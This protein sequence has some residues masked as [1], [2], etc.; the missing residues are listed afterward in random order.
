MNLLGIER[1]PPKDEKG[2]TYLAFIAH[3]Y[4]VST[5]EQLL[6]STED[7]RRIVLHRNMDGIKSLRQCAEIKRLGCVSKTKLPKMTRST[8]AMDNKTELCHN[9]IDDKRQEESTKVNITNQYR[10]RYVFQ[11]NSMYSTY[12]ANEIL[13]LKV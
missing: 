8:Y 3:L 9:T 1:A 2:I 5:E 4:R 12:S 7:N 6:S 10:F 13:D 11:G